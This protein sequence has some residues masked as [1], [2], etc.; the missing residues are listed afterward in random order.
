MTPYSRALIIISVVLAG[1]SLRSSPGGGNAGAGLHVA[2][3]ELLDA[4]VPV[5]LHGVNRAGTEYACIQGWG[6]FDGPSD[7]ASVAA[8]RA[9]N[10]N[11]VRIPLN[12]DCWLGI[13]GVP[14]E[15][16]GRHYID[17]IVRY[18]DRLHEHGMYAELSLMWGA[19]G[20]H[21]ATYQSGSPDADHAPEV[22]AQMAR[23]FKDDPDVI[24]A[25]WGETVVDADCF[26]HGGVCE[27]TFGAHDTPYE[28][29]GMQ[30]AVDVMRAEGFRGPIAIPG[31]DFANDMSSWLDHMPADPSGQLIAEMHLY[32]KNTCDTV[33]CLDT[34]VAPILAAGHPAIFGETGETYD[35]SS[36]GA[37]HISAFLRW[38]D[39]HGVGYMPWTWNTWGDCGTLISDPDGT[40]ANAYGAYVKTHFAELGQAGPASGMTQER[41]P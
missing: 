40:P 3:D 17:A 30:E 14:A 1:A 29:A 38:A 37:T 31:I 35:A 27:A 32:G 11:V 15:Y 2:G 28:T 24:L 41:N 5:H 18:V 4:G 21:R 26:L 12:E 10:A 39:A 6:I 19:P 16:S 34:T 22:W 13:G 25:P 23:T 8:I 36:C 9:W 33:A 20:K 7:E